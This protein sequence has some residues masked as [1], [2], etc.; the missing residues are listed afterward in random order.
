MPGNGKKHADK[1]R[2]R[3]WE[4]NTLKMFPFCLTLK[5]FVNNKKVFLGE[6]AY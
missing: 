3:N 5:Y 4:L 6:A 1:R 2:K